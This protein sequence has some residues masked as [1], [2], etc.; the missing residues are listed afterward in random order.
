MYVDVLHVEFVVYWTYAVLVSRMD[1][2]NV[3]R[4]SIV[5]SNRR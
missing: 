1:L 5:L 4:H 3:Q 2:F